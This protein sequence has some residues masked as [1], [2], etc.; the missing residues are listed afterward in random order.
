MPWSLPQRTCNP[1]QI[2]LKEFCSQPHWEL[3]SKLDV[4]SDAFVSLLLE[5]TIHMADTHNLLSQSCVLS[6]RSQNI[7]KHSSSQFVCDH[8]VSVLN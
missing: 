5:V 3:L 4:K 6:A 1:D 7:G 2:K 8:R